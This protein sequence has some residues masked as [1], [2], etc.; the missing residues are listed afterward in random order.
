MINR[1]KYILGRVKEALSIDVDSYTQPHQAESS[2]Q[3]L[4]RCIK[5]PDE[6]QYISQKA[7]QAA[8]KGIIDPTAVG[9]SVRQS[10]P[11]GSGWVGTA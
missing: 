4:I 10:A 6:Q 7:F 1:A 5:N 2:L 9:S 11:G 8:K 3:K